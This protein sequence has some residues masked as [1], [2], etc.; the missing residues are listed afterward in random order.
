MVVLTVTTLNSTKQVMYACLAASAPPAAIPDSSNLAKWDK[1]GWDEMGWNYFP[2]IQTQLTS[3]IWI[4]M[5]QVARSVSNHVIPQLNRG[6]AIALEAFL[7]PS[8]LHLIFT[9]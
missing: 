9:H 3:F 5:V 6:L 2:V 1:L 7:T 4:P 8:G